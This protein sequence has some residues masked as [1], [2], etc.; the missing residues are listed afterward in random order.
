MSWD[1]RK[2]GVLTADEIQEHMSEICSYF[3]MAE[4]DVHKMLNAAD[5]NKDGQIDYTEFIAAALDKKKLL[6][7]ENL[8]AAFNS[9][10]KNNMG[11][12]EKYNIEGI[13][14]YSD[15]A[16]QNTTEFWAA[17]I[18]GADQD[19]DGRINFDEFRS[20]MKDVMRKRASLY[21]LQP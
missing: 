15:N 21:V 1:T 9:L 13:L 2:D 5:I 3:N 16:M 7:E 18:A 14:G 6:S 4:P 11:Y 17:L 12:I 20:H 10:D 8:R 19:S